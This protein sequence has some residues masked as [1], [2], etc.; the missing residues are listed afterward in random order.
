M[1]KDSKGFSWLEIIVG[2]LIIFLIAKIL[3]PSI[4]SKPSEIHETSAVLS[5]HAIVAAEDNYA[6]AYDHGYSESLAVLGPPV[7]AMPNSTI[8][9][10]LDDE[11]AAGKKEGYSFTYKPGPADENGRIQS[12]TLTANPLKPGESG[13]RYYFVGPT[14]GDEKTRMIR[15]NPSRPATTEDKLLGS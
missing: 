5:L 2:I 13:T 8:A 3:V 10:Y 4:L 7:Q 1:V 9:G 14:L 12:Y 15:V 6:R 11:L